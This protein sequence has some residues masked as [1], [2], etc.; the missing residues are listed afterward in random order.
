MHKLPKSTRFQEPP[1]VK[2]QVINLLI[3]MMIHKIVVMMSEILS[4]NVYKK[5]YK[6]Y[7]KMQSNSFTSSI[8]RKKN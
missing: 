1:R 3:M 8:S 7:Q 5:N 4:N 2:E 6:H